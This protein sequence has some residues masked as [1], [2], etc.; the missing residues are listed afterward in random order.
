MTAIWL[1]LAAC[2]SC[3]VG[4]V[5]TR[6]LCGISCRPMLQFSLL[7]GPQIHL[8]PECKPWHFYQAIRCMLTGREAVLSLISQHGRTEAWYKRFSGLFWLALETFVPVFDLVDLPGDLPDRRNIKV[9]FSC[10]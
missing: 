10:L 3:F 9:D 5:R 4:N 7:R 1:C 8:Q 6:Q 2:C